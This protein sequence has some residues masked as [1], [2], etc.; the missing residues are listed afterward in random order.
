MSRR[1]GASA[2]G[3]KVVGGL[4]SSSGP[5]GLGGLPHQVIGGCL[6]GLPRFP[7]VA[8]ST[9]RA[10]TDSSRVCD[11]EGARLARRRGCPA[12]ANLCCPRSAGEPSEPW[13]TPS[14]FYEP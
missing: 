6:F 9:A 11:G 12:P 2:P 14:Y 8:A 5:F 13:Q 7:A 1:R 10:W 3:D 4:F